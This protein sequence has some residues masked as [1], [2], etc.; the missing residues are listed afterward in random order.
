MQRSFISM[1]IRTALL[2]LGVWLGV[3]A[4][5][6]TTADYTV[7]VKGKKAGKATL[8]I[9]RQQQHYQVDLTLYPN[10]L[11]KLFG[12]DDMRETAVGSITEE[13]FYPGSYKRQTLDGK[14]LMAVSINGEQASLDKQGEQESF[15]ISSQSQDPLTQIAQ[16][17]HDLQ[18]GKLASKYTLLTEKTLRD[19]TA[20]EQ[21][22]D[23]DRLVILTQQPRGERVLRLWFDKQGLLRRMQKNKRGKT[24]FDMIRQ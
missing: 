13:H 22:S 4:A 21:V 19:Y 10:V 2:L 17:Q 6:T 15:T 23:A 1:W 3:V 24:D 7:S 16:I 5:Q 12:I 20:K 9:T 11:A 18:R 14:T 8:S